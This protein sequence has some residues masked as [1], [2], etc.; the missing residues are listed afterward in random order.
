MQGERT[1]VCAS[2]V[3]SYSEMAEGVSQW[4]N[5][6]CNPF[7]KPSHYVRNK[8]QLRQVSDWMITKVPTLTHGQKICASCRKQ[9][10]HTSS[11]SPTP[12]ERRA[13]TPESPVEGSEFPDEGPESDPAVVTPPGE[14]LE[15]EPS[16][17]VALVNVCLE[18][19][20]E[21]PITK[22]NLKRA[23]KRSK[24]KVDKITTMMQRAM[25]SERPLCN[26]CEIVSQLRE[27]FQTATRSEKMQILT[28]LPK[29]WSVKRIQEEFGTTNFMARQAKELVKEKGVL[30]IP[31]LK[32]GHALTEQTVHLVQSFYQSDDISRVMPGRKDYVSVRVGE[33]RVHVQKRLVLCNL[34]ELY[35]TFKDQHPS[36]HIGFSKFA[37]LR[38]KHCVLAGASGTHTVCVCTYHQN[39]KLMIHAA[40]LDTSHKHIITQA[41]CNPSQPQCFLDKCTACPGTEM[42]RESMTI[43]FEKKAIV[44]VIY[45]QWVSVDRT[46]LETAS[47]PFEDFIDTFIEKVEVLIPHSFI[48]TQQAQF[49][50]E[51]KKELKEGELVVVA[52]FSENYSFVVQDAA[53]G[54]HWNNSQATIHP[55]VV[56]YQHSDKEHHISFVVVS[57]CLQHDTVAVHLFQRELIAFLKS[58]L[59]F[60]ITKITYFSDGAASQYKNRKNFVNLCSHEAD[61]GMK[62]EWHFSATSH[63]KGACDGVGGTVKRLAARASLQKPFDQQIMSP[64]QLYEWAK[65]NIPAIVFRYC[66]TEDYEV[67]KQELES[68]F[69]NSRTIPGTRKL[70]AFIP[71]SRHLVAVKLYS[72]SGDCKEEKV[73]KDEGELELDGLSGYVTCVYESEWWLACVLSVDSEN[74]EVKLN[75]L[76]PYGPT[77]SYRY[78]AIPD[79]LSVPSSDLLCRVSPRT[80][81]GRTYTITQKESREVTKKLTS[82]L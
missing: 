44:N 73:V 38:P 55:F 65:E 18:T 21:T 57:D 23:K 12:E 41:V 60:G 43:H 5:I 77:S 2:G 37:S 66:S 32:H 33:G 42:L 36:D 39:V 16:E 69:R 79:I 28:V 48:A 70:H 13:T 34:R 14:E 30:A 35:A 68:R 50:N 11:P 63:G 74:A 81:T 71:L 31:D 67:V 80:V 62:A 26:D 17:S 7:G 72:N 64:T 54:M 15:P 51:C 9:L 6:C 29:S 61:F 58:V 3:V 76:H 27:K 20:G 45:Q 1:I 52:D 59:P 40:G 75:F 53:Q 10:S 24:Q 22:T 8:K 56:Y 47:L 78:P 19:F 25:I 4:T 82:R 46:T 49:F